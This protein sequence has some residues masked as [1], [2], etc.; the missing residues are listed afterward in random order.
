M[1]KKTK[2]KTELEHLRKRVAELEQLEK[3]HNVI[4]EEL[5]AANQQLDAT[6][7]QLQ[8]SEQ[9]L[10][11]Y[12]EQLQASEQQLKSYNYEKILVHSFY[13]VGRICRIV[14]LHR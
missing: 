13:S 1:G 6:N 9:Q 5:K 7:Q 8:A 11:A 3:K 2:D 14:C 10:K 12:N 4:E